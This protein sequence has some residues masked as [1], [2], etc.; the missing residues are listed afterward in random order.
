VNENYWG[1]QP[2][3]EGIDIQIFTSPANLY[4]TFRTGGL[5]VA[6]QTLDPEQIASLE[7]EA[8]LRRLA[9]D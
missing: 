4:N 5:D 7:R 3:N 2:A 9:G 8:E 1:E 6:Y